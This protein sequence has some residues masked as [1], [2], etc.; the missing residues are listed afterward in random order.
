MT[1]RG[2]ALI[3]AIFFLGFCQLVALGFARLLPTELNGT[4][5]YQIDVA[6]SLAADAGIQYAVVYLE[7]KL[8]RE[9]EPVPGPQSTLVLESERLG[10]SLNGWDWRVTLHPDPQTPPLGNNPRRAYSIESQALLR[11]QVHRVVTVQVVQQSF[12]RY[13]RFTNTWPAVVSAWAGAQ[14][15][16][17][18]VHSNEIIRIGIHPGYYTNGDDQLFQA[19]V[20]SVGGIKY[21]PETLE[22]PPAT[23]AQ[24]RRLF[25]I[26]REPTRRR[27]KIEV[28][29]EP[30][31][32]RQASLAGGQPDPG[33]I[34]V[35]PGGGIFL[36][37]TVDEL[38]LAVENGEPVQYITMGGTTYK[39]IEQGPSANGRTRVVNTS[40]GAVVADHA[41]HPN[42]TIYATGSILSL[43][44]RNK[45]R[46]TIAVD[47]STGHKIVVGGNILQ[48]GASPSSPARDL[49]NRNALG[50][51][52]H[53]VEI[54]YRIDPATGPLVVHA[55]I[56]AGDGDGTGGFRTERLEEIPRD[57][58]HHNYIT[59]VGSVVEDCRNITAH[60]NPGSGWTTRFEF[61]PSLKDA[62][63]PYFP[64][65]PEF[66]MNGYSDR[67]DTEP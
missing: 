64:A 27:T 9:Q 65:E 58:L 43:H 40:S 23:E 22:P 48:A 61:D 51:I 54:P 52:C 10:L 66:E 8:S 12:V 62:P 6:S 41:G 55:A 25:N 11:D 46:H 34:T 57:D 3:L 18:P 17:G 26:P 16:S 53:T 33:S 32:L 59:F 63:P 44:G 39:V 4:L 1:R 47:S 20:T 15:F 5:R 13:A 29:W 21:T 42:G 49:D 35:R 30:N 19:K 45:G 56:M 24:Y 7:D 28:P 37:G 67:Y 2:T 14:H 36:R 38:R 60:I 31:M 50:L